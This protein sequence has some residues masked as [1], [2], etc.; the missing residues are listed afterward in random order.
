MRKDTRAIIEELQKGE[1]KSSEIVRLFEEANISGRTVTLK[2]LKRLAQSTI[3]FKTVYEDRTVIF[4]LKQEPI[5]KEDRSKLP[6]S[7]SILFGS[8]KYNTPM[9]KLNHRLFQFA[10]GV[11]TLMLTI[12]TFL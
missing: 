9:E 2:N 4:S 5:A 8:P 1:R 7:L 3:I 10:F 11:G 6:G 12:M